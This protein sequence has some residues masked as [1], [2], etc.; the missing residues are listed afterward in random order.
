MVDLKRRRIM[1]EITWLSN[2][3]EALSKALSTNKPVLL[4]FSAAPM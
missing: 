2:M 1:A 3:D 4:D